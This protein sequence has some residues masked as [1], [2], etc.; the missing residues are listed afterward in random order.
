M[1][2]FPLQP[3]RDASVFIEQLAPYD[4]PILLQ[5]LE[6]DEFDEEADGFAVEHDLSHGA[7]G[8]DAVWTGKEVWYDGF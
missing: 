2:K 7:V 5:Q 4:E 1:E 6:P 3:Q 8:R